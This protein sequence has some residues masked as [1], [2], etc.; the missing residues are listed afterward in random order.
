MSK[1]TESTTTGNDI[2]DLGD[3][4]S[5]IPSS[6]LLPSVPAPG[7]TQLP[8]YEQSLQPPDFS[9]ESSGS[10]SRPHSRPS[11]EIYHLFSRPEFEDSEAE[12]SRDGDYVHDFEHWEERITNQGNVVTHR[13]ELNDGEYS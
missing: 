2:A 7:Y 4:P 6:S 10:S 1:H 12:L 9:S 8:S 5:I 11:E 3:F 13:L